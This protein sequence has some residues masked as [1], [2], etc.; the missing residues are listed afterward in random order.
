ME[1]YYIIP[2]E[3]LDGTSAII[4]E[5]G[6]CDALDF[7]AAFLKIPEGEHISDYCEVLT[8]SEYE[9]EYGDE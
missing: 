1:R 8:E 5:G 9:E 7:A 6:Y 2:F 4:Y 3:D